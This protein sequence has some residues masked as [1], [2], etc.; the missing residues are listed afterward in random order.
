MKP[1]SFF[2]LAS[3]LVSRP[4][5]TPE[6]VAARMDEVLFAGSP[7]PAPVNVGTAERDAGRELDRLANLARTVK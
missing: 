1:Y 7:A 3:A 4:D 5:D 6:R 2:D